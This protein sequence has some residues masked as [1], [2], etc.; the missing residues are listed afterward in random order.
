MFNFQFSYYDTTHMYGEMSSVRTLSL[1]Y[2]NITLLSHSGHFE[3][4]QKF[5]F[6]GA[7]CQGSP[8]RSCSGKSPEHVDI[9]QHFTTAHVR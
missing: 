4:C 6:P 2:L 3:K 9:K 5:Y 1:K 8:L 7:H